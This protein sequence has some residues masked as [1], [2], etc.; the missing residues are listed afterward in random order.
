MVLDPAV[1]GAISHAEMERV[2]N[3]LEN[4]KAASTREAY[5]ADWNHFTAW[6]AA[7]GFESLPA[8]PGAIAVYL[9][10]L[11]D[12]GKKASTIARRMAAI[13]HRHKLAG[14]DPLPTASEGVRACTRGIRRTI[15]AL[16]QPKAPT[17]HHLIGKMLE[18]C[19]T[20]TLIGLRDRALLAFGFASTMRRSE[21]CALEVDDLAE[22]ADGLRVLIR[23]SKGDQEGVG[24]EIAIP[25]GYYLRPVEALQA[26]LEAAS[27][28]EG[29]VFRAVLLGGRVQASWTPECLCRRVKLY[30]S[31]SAWTLAA[32]ERT[33]CA[34]G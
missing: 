20:G 34:R 21:L 7:R 1:P 31:N 5:E 9:S 2:A 11:A 4:E 13:G 15:G 30:A 33:R 17:T 12:A 24:Q 22:V 14:V 32:S 10:H 19:D 26:W 27:I 23:K 8:S 25:R 6:C 3:Y 28:T 18:L 16:V 29:R